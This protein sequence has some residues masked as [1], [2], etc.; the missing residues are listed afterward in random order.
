MQQLFKKRT[1]FTLLILL[2]LCIVAMRFFD[3]PLKN[4]ISP[5]GIVSFELA[6][7]LSNSK[8]IID[9]WNEHSKASAGLSLGLDFL[10][11]GLYSLFIGLLIFRV[12]ERL[13]KGRSFYLVGKILIYAIFIAAFFDLI[14]NIALIKLILGDF[15]Q[16]WSSLAYYFATI[17]FGI[18]LLCIVYLL[19]AWTRM[20]LK[21]FIK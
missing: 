17:K 18:V 16:T 3:A 9:S 4:E 11:L 15:N 21:N 5:N 12:N 6:K 8:A 1:F 2:V 20:L 7:E 14:E 10:F 13:W 19:I